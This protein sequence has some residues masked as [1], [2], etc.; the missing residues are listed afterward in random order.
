MLKRQ[1]K[2][3]IEVVKTKGTVNAA[4]TGEESEF[5]TL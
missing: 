4:E 3:L 2:E 1:Q 5:T